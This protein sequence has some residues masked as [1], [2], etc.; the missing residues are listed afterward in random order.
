MVMVLK[1]LSITLS[2]LHALVDAALIEADCDYLQGRA[3]MA[4]DE[5]ILD[6]LFEKAA[7]SARK[8]IAEIDRATE[9]NF[10]NN[11]LRLVLTKLSTDIST[12]L[13]ILQSF[14]SVIKASVKPS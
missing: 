12:Q 2:V 7:A 4:S 13:E 5:E 10:T 6:G 8:S 1:Q 14:R 3:R 11:G 9:D